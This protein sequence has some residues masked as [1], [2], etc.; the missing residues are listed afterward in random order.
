[1]K[2]RLKNNLSGYPAPFNYEGRK[3]IPAGSE[4]LVENYD[5]TPEEAKVFWNGVA[6]VVNKESLKILEDHA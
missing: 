5:H 3:T 4:I 6:Y 1:M 2:V